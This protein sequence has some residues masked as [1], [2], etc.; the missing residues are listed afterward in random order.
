MF[1]GDDSVTKNLKRIW[2]IVNPMSR[3]RRGLIAKFRGW[4]ST[5]VGALGSGN[6][7]PDIGGLAQ[8]FVDRSMLAY[9]PADAIARVQSQN[10]TREFV[11]AW[12]SFAE[13]KANHEGIISANMAAASEKIRVRNTANGWLVSVAN[14]HRV[15]VEGSIASGNFKQFVK[16]DDPREVDIEIECNG[17]IA[18]CTIDDITVLLQFVRNNVHYD[19]SLETA[20]FDHAVNVTVG[21]PQNAN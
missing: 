18:V 7:T 2:P 16:V 4:A 15:A 20:G 5:L 13:D 1:H 21:R 12:R 14:Y 10:K 3:F 6:T 11:T 9:N 8:R 19:G 17:A